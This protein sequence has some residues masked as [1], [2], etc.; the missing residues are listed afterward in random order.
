VIAG[1][2]SPPF[3]AL[4]P[5]ELDESIK[6]IND[7][8]AGIVFIGLGCPRQDVFAA[9]NK[10]KIKAVS[11]RSARR[12]IS[13]PARR[14]PPRR[15]CRSAGSSGSTASRRSRRGLWKRYLSIHTTFAFLLT[16]RLILGR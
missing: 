3:R 2:E 14:A 11:R 5:Q 16:R 12:S 7:S 10:H 6:R 15:G 4:A 13:T 8:G 1:V 9:E